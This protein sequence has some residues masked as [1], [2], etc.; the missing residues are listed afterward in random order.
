MRNTRLVELG[1]LAGLTAA[2]VLS[3]AIQNSRVP[4]SLGVTDG[5]LAPMPRSPNAVSSQTHKDGMKVDA[6]GFHGDLDS[7]REKIL[8][9]LENLGNA[10][11]I[12]EESH[13][14]H[15]VFTTPTMKYR[16][17]VEFYFDESA[18]VIHYRS[19]SRIGYGD[20]GLNRERYEK[21]RR[22]YER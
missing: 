11:V 17:D 21:I 22:L 14:I 16:D 3:M 5:R 1:V 10:V 2:A 15:A 18:S 20:M 7:S 6:L 8:A 19:A 9:I 13:Y 4:K 12:S